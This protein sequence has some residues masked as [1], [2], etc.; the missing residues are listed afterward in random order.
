MPEASVERRPR[1]LR[2]IYVTPQE[3]RRVVRSAAPVSC[4][5]LRQLAVG[6]ALRYLVCDLGSG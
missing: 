1:R 3:S 2:I 5:R 6:P 4:G